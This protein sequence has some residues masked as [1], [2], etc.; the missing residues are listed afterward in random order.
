MA[1]YDGASAAVGLS[2]QSQASEAFDAVDGAAGDIPEAENDETWSG[3]SGVSIPVARDENRTSH[4]G[5]EHRYHVCA[6]GG[7]VHVPGGNHGVVQPVHGLVAVVQH[8]GWSVLPGSVERS[9]GTWEASH[10]QHRSRG[11]VHL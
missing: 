1:P 9:A 3:T 11:T 6:D 8:V 2:S 7:R 4:A 10:I 5:L